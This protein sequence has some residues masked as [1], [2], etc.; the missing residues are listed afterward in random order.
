MKPLEIVLVKTVLKSHFDIDPDKLKGLYYYGSINYGT[1]QEN[2]D[3]DFV[4]I[5]DMNNND[6]LQYETPD[7]DIHIISINHYKTLLKQHDIMALETFFNPTPIIPYSTEFELDLK[8]L[9]HK[10]SAIVSNSWVKAKKKVNLLGEDDYIGYKSLF[11]SIRILDFAVQL[12]ETGKI[13]DFQ[14][15]K[16]IWNEINFLVYA[17]KSIDEIMAHFKPNHNAMASK[18][19]ALAPKD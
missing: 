18:F 14:K 16:P 3:Y 15:M 13:N 2:S 12:A 19:R 4:A 6:Y 9:R 5:V 11:H 7:V 1:N 10:I 8:T 17:G